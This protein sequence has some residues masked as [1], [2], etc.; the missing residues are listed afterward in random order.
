M[1][2]RGVGWEALNG[3]VPDQL[4]KYWQYSLQ[5]LQIAR[6]AWPAHLQEIQKIEPA[7]RRDF[8]IDAEA[9]RLSAHHGGPVIA[10]GS[11]GSMP[12]TAKFLH[13]IASLRQ[14]AVVL[15]GLDTDLDDESWQIIGGIRDAQGKFTTPPASNHPQFAMHITCSHHCSCIPFFSYF[16]YSS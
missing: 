16:R 10:A 7:A 5:F 2:T 14:G 11:T 4:D 1:V 6:Q 3:L 13:V 12:S 8:L 9:K 15:P